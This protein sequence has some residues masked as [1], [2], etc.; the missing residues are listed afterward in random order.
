MGGD[1]GR[2]STGLASLGGAGLDEGLPREPLRHV[3]GDP[4]HVRVHSVAGDPHPRIHDGEYHRVQREDEGAGERELR[5]DPRQEDD[6]DHQL[7]RVEAGD[8]HARVDERRSLMDVVKHPRRDRPGPLLGEETNAQALQVLEELAPDVG[9]DPVAEV[10]V[11]VA[12]PVDDDSVEHCRDRGELGVA[13]QSDAAGR[14]RDAL[15]RGRRQGRRNH[16]VDDRTDDPRIGEG[17]RESHRS[18]RNREE[19]VAAVPSDISEK[20]RERA[21]HRPPIARERPAARPSTPSRASTRRRSRRVISSA[22][23]A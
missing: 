14:H 23:G 9:D 12:A 21:S 1:V 13:P 18:E 11:E 3:A 22:R 17:Q 20:T 16:G 8:D 15:R 7:H 19:R 4:R 6:R 2:E 10:H 5:A